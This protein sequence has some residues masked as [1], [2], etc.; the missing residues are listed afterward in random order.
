MAS[1]Q[2]ITLKP[3]ENAT[4]WYNFKEWIFANT[5]TG[6]GSLDL[7]HFEPYQVGYAGNQREQYRV[8]IDGVELQTQWLNNPLFSLPNYTISDLDSVVIVEGKH[9]LA[10][11]NIYIYPHS[12]N[13]TVS[14]YTARINQ[15]NDPGPLIETD[16]FSPNVEYINKPA[17]IYIAQNFNSVKAILSYTHENYSRTGLLGYSDSF[18]YTERTNIYGRTSYQTSDGDQSIPRIISH[19]VN[20]LVTHT[21]KK[22][23]LSF[24]IGLNVTPE[25]Y[26]WHD[27]AG[28]EIPFES[29]QY[30]VGGTYR[31]KRNSFYKNSQISF[32]SVSADTLLLQGLDALYRLEEKK[33]KHES[34]FSFR[35]L[36]SPG[37]ITI[38]NRLYHISD[39]A[40]MNRYSYFDNEISIHQKFSDYLTLHATLG[41]IN[42][43]VAASNQITDSHF[44]RAGF[45]SRLLNK[46]TFHPTLITRNI[47]FIVDNPDTYNLSN[48]SS[49]VEKLTFAEYSYNVKKDS[50]MFSGRLI[51]QHFWNYV[52]EDI[53]YFYLGN[54]RR[55][56]SSLYYFDTSSVGTLGFFTQLSLKLNSKISSKT[57]LSGNLGLYGNNSFKNFYERVPAY[58][59]SE[60]VQYKAHENFV[61]ELFFR[62]IPARR[63]VEYENLEEQTGFPPSRVRP[64]P[65]LNFSTGMWFF[66]RRLETKLTLRNLLNKT[67][68]YDTHGQYYFMSINV[69]GKINFRY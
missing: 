45:E 31:N 25:N 29:F 27:L 18:T 41:N 5:N 21:N 40:R 22:R 24:L 12:K 34:N 32:S 39:K 42:N 10:S 58:I 43:S 57:I 54:R 44:I 28:I 37:F 50:Y 53:N 63:I 8:F 35:L 7:V 61:L 6:Y 60:I 19:N 20:S 56:G 52:N 3:S 46:A 67:E 48:Q 51:Y 23:D 64:F 36:K 26:D 17:S 55:L 2:S 15:I 47:G 30:Q 66:N 14:L 62:Y 11:T 13:N 4:D 68:A 9:S 16:D 69:S 59:F 38:K 49:H 65:L 33:I 1:G